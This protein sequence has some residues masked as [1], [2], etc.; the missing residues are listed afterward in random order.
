MSTALIFAEKGKIGPGGT[1][2]L[3]WD[4]IILQKHPG[5]NEQKNL[6][7]FDFHIYPLDI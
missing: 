1:D 6:T 5:R 2:F 7:I 4:V 3:V